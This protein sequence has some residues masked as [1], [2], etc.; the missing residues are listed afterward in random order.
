MS[1]A[2]TILDQLGGS[3]FLM[4]TGAKNLI[5]ISNGLSFKVGRNAKGVSH[6]RVTLTDADDY[7]VE[8]LACRAGDIKTKSHCAGVYSDNLQSIFTAHTGLDTRL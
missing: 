6:V 7:D 4:M 8:F 1:V 3:R 5:G 2:R